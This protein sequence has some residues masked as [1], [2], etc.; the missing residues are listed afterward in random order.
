MTH[1][2]LV[3]ASLAAGTTLG[4]LWMVVSIAEPQRSSLQA[5]LHHPEPK[6]SQIAASTTQPV[7]PRSHEVRTPREDM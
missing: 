2:Q 7:S 3:A 1:V 4:L 5:R 6:T